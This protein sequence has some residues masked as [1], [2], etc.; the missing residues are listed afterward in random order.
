MGTQQDMLECK[1]CSKSTM[2]TRTTPNTILHIFL[3]FVTAGVWFLIW[4]LFI[5]KG[6]Y[7]CTTCGNA[8]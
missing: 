1:K 7:K 3:M 4:L 2:H 5:H 6:S 8:R